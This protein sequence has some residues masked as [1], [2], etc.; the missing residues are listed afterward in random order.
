LRDEK[1]SKGQQ[2]DWIFAM[3]LKAQDRIIV[4]LDLETPEQALQ[5][6]ESVRAVFPFFK[7]GMKLFTK[8]GPEFVRQILQKGRVFLDLKFYDIPSIVSEAVANAAQIGVSLL[9]VH[10]SGGSEMIKLSM[11]KLDP[12]QGSCKLL[13]VTVLTSMDSLSEFGIDRSASEQA[14]LL[15]NVAYHSGA[16]GIV[17]SPQELEKLR[18]RFPSPFLILTPG[19]RGA[20]DAAGDQKRTASASEALQAGADYLVIGR[21]IIAATDPVEA[22]KRIAAEIS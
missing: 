16:N 14:E 10:A 21:P 8:G 15:A 7:I 6:A 1:N 22:A 9:T 12:F 13:A 20:S 4:A 2:L 5:M 11:Q 19:I 18:S 3:N 17:C